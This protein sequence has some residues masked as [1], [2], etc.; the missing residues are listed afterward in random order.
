MRCCQAVPWRRGFA[1]PLHL[2]TSPHH[3][4][5]CVGFVARMTS[6]RQMFF[7]V[8]LR[9]SSLGI[10]PW[11]AGRLKTLRQ[12]HV[13]ITLCSSSTRCWHRAGRT[14]CCISV[15]SWNCPEWQSVP[16]L[17]LFK[18]FWFAEDLGIFRFVPTFSTFS[19]WT[20]VWNRDL[21]KT[22]G[23]WKGLLLWNSGSR[24]H[25][26]RLT[27]SSQG[28]AVCLQAMPLV[29]L[30]REMVDLVELNE[31]IYL[32]SRDASSVR[33]TLIPAPIWRRVHSFWEFQY[34]DPQPKRTSGWTVTVDANI[35]FY[36]PNIACNTSSVWLTHTFA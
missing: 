10:G 29:N 2:F 24:Y 22:T 5:L 23:R 32:A 30:L 25:Q 16:S 8:L 20:K 28:T 7:L 11:Y 18:R 33:T 12:H 34:T 13:S 9:S 26:Q 21:R 19:L 1:R 6:C 15:L 31:F 35:C 27:A 14:H 17:W 3:L 36:I 4:G